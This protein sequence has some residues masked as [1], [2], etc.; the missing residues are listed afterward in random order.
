MADNTDFTDNLSNLEE[1]QNAEEDNRD[2]IREADLFLN[3]RDG[4]W[5][6][7]TTE[8]MGGKP[9]LTFDYCNP[10]I[11][12][13]IGEMES[14]DFA[15]SVKPA[16]GEATKDTAE[17]YA[18]I[19]RNIENISGA[20]YIYKHAAREMTGTGLSGWRIVSDYRDSD[21]FQ[22]DLMIQ[23]VY[24]FKDRVWYDSNAARRTMEDA[25]DC[26]VLT[27]MTRQAY[28]K[29]YPKGSGLSVG[30]D[31]DS[32]AYTHKKTHEVIIGEWLYKKFKERELAL[33]S[34]NA[35][36]E[37]TD[38]FDKVRDELFRQN[39]TVERTKKRKV[40]TVYQRLFDGGGWLKESA[41]TVFEFIPIVPIYA[42]FGISENKVIYW[43]AVEKWMDAQRSI[44]FSE[45]R[46]LEEAALSPREKVWMTKDQAKSPDVRATLRTANTN[47]DSHQLYDHK[48]GQQPPFRPPK[49]QPNT[50][51]M[52]TAQSAQQYMNR[53]MPQESL[54]QS[55]SG[56]S[57]IGMQTLINKGDNSN[58]K[59]FT[60]TEIGIAHSCR[61]LV[62]A[63]P[64]VYDTKQEMQLLGQDGTIDSVTIKDKV[65]DEQT[66]EIVELN[67]LSK[68]QYHVTCSA[69]PAFHNRQQETVQSIIDV[70]GIAPDVAAQGSDILVSNIASPGMDLLAERIRQ[71]K[72]AAGQIPESQLTDEEKELLAQ[73]SEQGQ[74]PSA[75]DQALIAEA[76]ARTSEVEAK[77]AD[78]I[79][80]I[81]ERDQNF[82]LKVAK[83]EQDQE[84]TFL[85]FQNE[86]VK[87]DQE[88]RKMIMKA[89]S[90]QTDQLNKM[91]DTLKTLREAQGVDTIVGPNSVES[92]I[93]QAELITEKQEAVETGTAPISREPQT[94]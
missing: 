75:V 49:Q 57:G 73:I 34:N 94:T 40:A 61:I 93:N 78:T 79:S 48:D 59:Y 33:L 67:D 9:R 15:I 10:I 30:E 43:G 47:T 80:R 45:S 46:K 28:D 89:I 65:F 16:G 35:V 24:N 50:V 20:R 91:A 26:W 4:Q 13:I 38:D 39:I 37:V 18:G 5:N 66:G 69:G 60:A 42:N 71:Q 31:R 17:N 82:Q 72:V 64:K 27:S 63:I 23:P 3:K 81:E 11:D 32:E 21:S 70:A 83:L 2:A 29:K 22:Q 56:R 85:K 86:Q 12:D 53:S 6:P 36:V 1:A 88:E 7:Y 68:G 8:K 84:E 52:E 51:L 87:N 25:N 76:Q 14:M 62:K 55:P 54:G 41:K 74:E 90:D 44:N 19:I 58:Y 77:T 92:Y